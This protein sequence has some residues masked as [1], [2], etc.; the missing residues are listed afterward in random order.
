M[1]SR[2]FLRNIEATKSGNTTRDRPNSQASGRGRD[3]TKVVCFRCQKMGHYQRFC[4]NQ[5][6]VVAAMEW[7]C[8]D[9]K[10]YQ[11]PDGV[12][13]WGSFPDFQ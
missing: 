4:R 2:E 6:G 12:N 11:D 7:F 3:M 13:Q 1:F 5:S 8:E 10:D 9:H